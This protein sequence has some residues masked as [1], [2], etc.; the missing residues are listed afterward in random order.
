[1]R[2]LVRAGGFDG[3]GV[4]V[5]VGGGGWSTSGTA[6]VTGGTGGLGVCVARWL[7]GC[8]AEHVV[9]VS[10]RGAGAVGV[11]GVRAE[12]EGLG[13]RVSVV[14]CDVADRDGLAGVIAGIGE[15]VPLRTVVHA[16]GVNTGTVALESLTR[17]RLHEELA[18]K[19]DGAWHL[20]A[21][22]AGMELDAFVL[23]SSGAAAWGSGGQAGYAAANACLDSLAAHRRAR[24]RT[25]TSIAWGAWSGA[26]MVGATPGQDA[27]LRRLGVVPM[28]PDLAVSALQQ[29]LDDDETAIVVADLDW[30]RF[31]P[32]FT[33]TRPSPLLSALPEAARPAA[34]AEKESPAG[35][36]GLSARLVDLSARER[37]VFLVELVLR[38]AAEVLG[39]TSGQAIVADQT[40]RDIGFDSFTA[41][42]LRDRIARTTGLTLPATTVFDHPSALRLAAHLGS[43]LDG[44]G[45]NEDTAAPGA[46][47]GPAAEDPVVIVGMACRY[48]G[49][50]TG[51]EDLWRL[52]AEGTDAITPF[53]AD[54]GWDLAA[55]SAPGG[56]GFSTTR[57][58]GFLHDA[59]GFD[60]DFFGI[61]PREALTMDPQQRLLL[62]TSWE[63]LERAGIDPRAT[64]GSRTGV[65]AGVTDQGYGPPLHQP[66]EDGDP[67]ALTGTAASVASGRV[68][69][70]LGL[71][72]PALSVDTACSSSLVAMH[73]AAQSLRRD[74]CSL[75]L[76]GGVTVMATPGPFVAFTRQG[77]LSPD[78]R[79]KSFSQEA[80]GTGWSEGVGM[81]VLER[82][83]DARRNGHRILAV[84]RGS[85]VN[86]DGAS[87]GLTAPNGLAQERVI[88][89]ALADAGLQPAEVAAVEAH[90]TG[91]RL[92][93]PIEGRALLATY[94]QDRPGEEP[95]WLGSLKSNIGHAQ[96]AAGVGG[97][98]KMVKA[99]E[100]GV[101]PRTLHADRPSSEVDWAAGAVRL[102]AE[103]RPWDG[104]RRAAVSSF[105]ISGTNAHLILEAGP[106]TSVS[107]ER[108]PGADGP[109]GPVPWM[110]SGQTEGA[111]RDQA[112]ALLDRTGEADVHDIGLSLATTRALLHHRAVVVARDAEG[113]RAGL[114]A[115][116]A[117]DPAQP[118]V[119]TPP[120]PGGLGFLFSG[121][122]AQ[123][124]GMGQELAAAF[125][126][127][128]SAFAEASA[129]VGG[130][131]VDDAEVLRGTAM[132]QR[133]L[134]AFQVALYR[135]WESWGVVPDAVIGHSVG[136]VA[137]AH[138]AG[139]LSLED[140]C[141]LVAAR[142]DL[143]ER[144]A[145][146]GG[147]MMSV[148]AS[149]DEVTGTLA[150]GV[151]LAAVNG[152][153]SVVLS[154]DA[155]AVEAYAARWP[156][157]RG[158]R[159]SHAFHSHHMDGMLDAFAAVVRELTFHP[160]SLPMPAAGDVTDPD[161]W[162]RQVREPVRFLDGVRQLLA[163]G[164]RTFCEI[165]PDAVLTGL[166]EE[167]ADDVP[168]VRFVP[169]AR[170]GSPEEI[171]TVRALGELAAHGVTPRWDRVFPGARPTDLPTYAFQRRRYWLGPRQPDG[172]FWALVRQQDLS[173]LTESLRV[174]GDPRL[175]EVLPALARWHRRGEDSAALGRWR[176]EL[177]W[178]PVAADPPAEVTG[179]WL[180]APATA[181]DPLAD[182]VVLALAERGA[183][184]AVVRPEDVPAR[185]ARR[186][187]AGVVVLL[188]AADGPGEADGGS[189]AVP[190][191]D[192]A[193]A[194]VE[195]VRR[196]AAEET[197]APLWFVTRG[198]VAVDGEVPLSG[199]G[200]SLLWGLGPVLRDERPELWGGVVDVPAE[201]SA[202]A[203]ELLV[204]ALTSGWDQLAV[205]DGGLRTR[206]LVRAPYDRTVWRPSGTVL[207]T[208]GT[209][210]LGRH[211]ARWLAAEGAGHVVLAGRRG[212]DAP[213]V[214]ELCAELT[215][216]GVTA[217]AVSC[218]IRDRA[219][220]A[221]L[222]DRCSPDAVVHAA[223]VVDDTT[224]DGLTPHRVDQVLRT[225]AL[226]AWHLHQLTRDRPL[227]AF[228]LFSSVAGTLGTAGQ[229]NY[230]PGNAFLDALAA[231]RHALGLPATS[232][233]WGPWAGD[234]LAAAD[235]VAGA[236]GRHGFTPMDPALAVRALAATEVPFALVMDADW[237]RFPA[238]RA[239]SVVA[240]LVPDRAAEPAPGLL[241]RLSG[242]SEAE[243]A[244]LVRQTVRSALAAVLGHRDPG[245][246]GE[247]RTLTELGLDSMTAVELRNRLRA[248]TGLHLSATLAYNHP[249]AEELARHLHDRLRERTAP[250]ASSL[251]AELDRLE[252]AVAALPPGGD[253]RGAVAE[254]LR[255]LLGEIAPDPAHER[256]LD[257]V[258]QDE[259]L[260]LIDDEFGR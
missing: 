256:D 29:A 240:G 163:R 223:A 203:A 255:A 81:L 16:A 180:V 27:L 8:G 190:G 97:V 125:P 33:A 199:P 106:D 172:D 219:A 160:P 192:E 213:G 68:S 5:G 73:L 137:A 142:A 85:A 18:V 197:G 32:T 154:G 241:D 204:T 189:P 1:G 10:R 183:D 209:G 169:S 91:T 257:D 2:R 258:T 105:G 109:R 235:A 54:R 135:L 245:T 260:A 3:V 62:E 101:L 17:E 36:P 252:A 248:Q 130:V 88:R 31:L 215:A 56:S 14:A 146:G 37:S 152:P 111:L 222:L 166:G 55:L 188:P 82:Q 174:D 64:R 23:F 149:E 77:G 164:V 233:A 229:G 83:S 253:E 124:P 195:L 35:D 22:T 173:A 254:R 80:D 87:N 52:I 63:A 89:Q 155:E 191:L 19:V 129:G 156:G 239:P 108:R 238:E 202:T 107:A 230:A 90:G 132:A 12:L 226:P 151:S 170:R 182:A 66:A 193:A 103:A 61:S 117:G 126:A 34:P 228:V 200:H 236:A 70:V 99:M 49:G 214:A 24:G 131:R 177:T 196:I 247:D 225:K 212:G 234:G 4:G 102:L 176:Y 168:G 41:V 48:P 72:G 44:T 9:L 100:H 147:V 187:V 184:P 114:A 120:A 218:D 206:R 26:G 216:G 157:A 84:L 76:A 127:F 251:T 232:I 141:R 242:L 50:V 165:G 123:L 244:R 249:T 171:R 28:R 159:V 140:A 30:P 208:G 119:T 227:S 60:A 78:G 207:V 104:P 116:A 69:Y 217:T 198:A 40:F 186:P 181:G 58:G 98:I 47:V 6:L 74:E 95:L 45:T 110:V 79:C 210:A 46:P 246:L 13:A 250:A 65:F 57:S 113:F 136:E 150:D 51:P 7:V 11:E 133:A 139:V 115:L 59:G 194:T 53:P 158:L 161:H 145:E 21:L 75:A 20:D 121:Q 39:H 224:L 92:G 25:A 243:Q 94:G 179:T 220:L 86:Q 185:V 153:R 71:E 96:A 167:C 148:R 144:L 221:E 128:A 231:H 93:D 38:E 205:T 259:L 162:V 112:R 42:E 138:V 178:H 201:P 134:F 175:S 67:Y 43:L 237:E 211:V 122:G 143:M 15:E 118:V